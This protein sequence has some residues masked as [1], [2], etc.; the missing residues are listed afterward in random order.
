MVASST[1]AA[2]A[3][4]APTRPPGGDSGPLSSSSGASA[5]LTIGWPPLFWRPAPKR[6]WALVPRTP[7]CRPAEGFSCG[8]ALAEGTPLRLCLVTRCPGNRLD[9]RS[10]SW[11]MSS[12]APDRNGRPSL[13]PQAST[14]PLSPRSP[15]ISP[16]SGT[17]AMQPTLLFPPTT[18]IIGDSIARVT[19]SLYPP[20]HCSRRRRSTCLLPASLPTPQPPPLKMALQNTRSLNNKGHILADFLTDNNLDYLCQTETWHN[21]LNLFSLNQAT[22]PGYSYMHQPCLTGRGSGIAFIHKQTLKTTPIPTLSVHPFENIYVK[23]P[24]PTPLVIIT[25]YRPPKPHPSFFSDF[26]DF[27]THL[28]TISSSVLLLGDFNFHIDNPTC[29]QASDF[30]GSTRHHQPHPASYTNHL[31]LYSTALNSTRSSYYSNLIHS[32]SSNQKALFSTVNK[33]LHPIDSI[34][35]TFTPEKCNSFLSSFQSKI[36]TIYN[37][38]PP[39]SI[40]SSSPHPISTLP[41]LTSFSN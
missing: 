39:P 26:S 12:A 3:P 8:L 20:Y 9:H 28:S 34:S 22:P 10:E 33:L 25:I 41:L 4:M 36:N 29:K 2:G 16:A 40:P 30:L 31:H 14:A 1:V 17:G 13:L 11:T 37:S 23:L 18:L 35:I 6:H 24:G 21:H 19:S 32:G 5:G 15:A 38:L 27:V 7:P